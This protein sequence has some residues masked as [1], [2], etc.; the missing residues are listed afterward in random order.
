MDEKTRNWLG[1][2]IKIIS[3]EIR[4][5]GFDIDKLTEN[6]EFD[7]R[8]IIY[9][10]ECPCYE[11]GKFCHENGVEYKRYC[12]LCSCNH[13]DNSK[14]EGGCSIGN[15][16]EKG[17]YFDRSIFRLNDIW[18]CGDCLYPHTRTAT[19]RFL[20]HLKRKS[21]NKKNVEKIL[22]NFFGLIQ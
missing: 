2:R 9:S 14:Q 18:D 13:Y 10:N 3:E 21:N 7:K 20:R 16:C 8:R 6:F 4:K 15:P 1:K 19:Q 5:T 17:C 12:L 22:Q 11:T